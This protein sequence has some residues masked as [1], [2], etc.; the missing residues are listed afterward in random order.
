MIQAQAQT[1]VVEEACREK[2]INLYNV[3]LWEYTDTSSDSFVAPSQPFVTK[4]DSVVPSMPQNVPN[5]VFGDP[6]E[7]DL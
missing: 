6:T 2:N 4:T 7:E 5:S 1:V 3:T